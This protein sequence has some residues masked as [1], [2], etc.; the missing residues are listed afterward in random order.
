MRK[1]VHASG[2][3]ELIESQQ[4]IIE[5]VS[6]ENEIIFENDNKDF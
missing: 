3:T 4:T 5:V 1:I 2:S 6:K